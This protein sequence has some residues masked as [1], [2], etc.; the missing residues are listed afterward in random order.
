MIDAERLKETRL[1]CDLT[2][3]E[4]GKFLGISDKYVSAF[5]SGKRSRASK[6]V[7]AK[8]ESFLCSPP[9][10]EDLDS[11]KRSIERTKRYQATVEELVE[12]SLEVVEEGLQESPDGSKL[13]IFTSRNILEANSPD[14]LDKL[15]HYLNNHPN[16]EFHYIIPSEELTQSES[17]IGEWKSAYQTMV[18]AIEERVL[19]HIKS[20]YP[21]LEKKFH[22]HRMKCGLIFHP[23]CKTILRVI[24]EQNG[25]S[26]FEGHLELNI[27]ETDS[28]FFTLNEEQINQLRFYISKFSINKIIQ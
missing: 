19:G 17:V 22:L 14:Q 23:F 25:R 16:S 26:I 13:L 11:F 18:V 8:I 2:Q 15:V 24:P 21:N 28:V 20:H 1:G 6:A 27:S 4:L 5:E 10:Q 9:S 12:S 7:E 3:T